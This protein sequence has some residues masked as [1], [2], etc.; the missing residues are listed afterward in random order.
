MA[1]TTG[2]PIGHASVQ[3]FAGTQ[4]PGLRRLHRGRRSGDEYGSR[5]RRAARTSASW[6]GFQRR[7]PDREACEQRQSDPL[8]WRV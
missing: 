1:Q 2:K 4:S 7:D 3:Q 8:P 5:A 6:M